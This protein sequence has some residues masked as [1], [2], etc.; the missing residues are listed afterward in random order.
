MKY[1]KPEMEFVNTGKYV[2]LTT[3][4]NG[5]SLDEG[6]GSIGDADDIM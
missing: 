4:S 2:P 3:L 1:E 6:G 5:G